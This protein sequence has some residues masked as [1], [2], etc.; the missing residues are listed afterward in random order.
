MNAPTPS[1]P[2]PR[3][4]RAEPANPLGPALT[5]GAHANLTLV[6]SV[7]VA[8]AL[9]LV[10]ILGALTA[11][12]ALSSFASDVQGALRERLRTTYD[13]D[14]APAPEPPPLPTAAPEPEPES[15]PT[16][17]PPP[18]APRA[19]AAPEPASSPPPA[20]QAGKVLTAPPDPNQPVD[21]TGEGFVTGE[22]DTYAGGTTAASGTS[23]TAVHD[24]NAGRPAAPSGTGT[25]KTPSA[26]SAPPKDL[27]RAPRPTSSNWSCPFPPEADQDQVDYAAVSLV[28]TVGADG[29]ARSVSVLSDPGHG[30]GRMARQCAMSR[31]YSV[32]L[33]KLG[34][35]TT[36]TTPPITVRFNR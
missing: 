28:V 30:F 2:S 13:V 10:A 8:A 16:P 20:A 1:A 5:L 18:T 36:Q 12:V 19:A 27:S 3:D 6:V 25:A 35:P 17:I 31:V 9:H 34:Q 26:P 22:G 24:P 14:E 29:R 33:D 4:G 11:L 15:P 32:G 21:L 23:T 7:A